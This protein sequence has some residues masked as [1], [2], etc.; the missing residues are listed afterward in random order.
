MTSTV[1][2][3]FKANF[4]QMSNK[5]IILA[6]MS[7]RVK[8][9][10]EILKFL[11]LLENDPESECELNHPNSDEICYNMGLMKLLFFMHGRLCLHNSALQFMYF[12]VFL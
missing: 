2:D 9:Y 10:E 11:R 1:K 3:Q 12:P 7:R 5:I 4:S 8:C 6:K